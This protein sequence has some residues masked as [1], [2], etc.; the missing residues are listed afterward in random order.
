MVSRRSTPQ[1]AQKRQSKLQ[2][3]MRAGEE[4]MDV[5]KTKSVSKSSQCRED[6]VRRDPQDPTGG[7]VMGK[8]HGD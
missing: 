4:R 5:S 8:H 1:A 7:T 3:I 2:H 6:V